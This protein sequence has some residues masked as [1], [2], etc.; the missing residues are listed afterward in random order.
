MKKSVQMYAIRAL[1]SGNLEKALETVAKIGYDGVEF[2]GFFDHTAKAV[3]GWL[4]KYG[5]EVSGAHVPSHL[6]LDNPDET[7]EFHKEIGNTRIILPSFTLDNREDITILVEKLKEVAPKYAAA[8]M[9]LFYHNHSHEFEKVDGRCIIDILAEETKGILNLEF[10]AYWVYRGNE[11]P[12]NYLKKYADR[13]EIFHAKDGIGEESTTLGEGAVD[14]KGVF[15]FAKENNML[16]AVAE[17]EG[18]QEADSQVEA[19][20]KDYTAMVNLLG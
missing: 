11:C 20:A 16:W 6:M 7:I 12:V 18:S 9:K 15:A 1:A 17:S 14:I 3:S 5:L 10:D 2:A 8:G 13:V 19:I 4:K